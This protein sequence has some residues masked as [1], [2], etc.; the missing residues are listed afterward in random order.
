MFTPR[1]LIAVV[2]NNDLPEGD[3][4]DSGAE[5]H[6]EALVDAGCRVMSGGQSGVM[7]A[8]SRGAK[9]SVRYREGD[10]LALLPGMDH[11]DVNADVDIAIPTGVGYARNSIVALSHAVIA[12]G[13]G[14]VGELCRGLGVWG[15][16]CRNDCRPAPSAP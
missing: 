4:R 16:P 5:A 1:P 15:R 6:G 10:V 14:G 2:G 3:P 12:V 11:Q 13:G 8:V 7:A 9:R